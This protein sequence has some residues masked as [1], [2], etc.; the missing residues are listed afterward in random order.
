MQD[1]IALT[2]GDSKKYSVATPGVGTTP[3][4]AAELN[5]Y[6]L[7]IQM[8]RPRREALH[9]LALRSGVPDMNALTALLKG[10]QIRRNDAKKYVA[11]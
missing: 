4:L 6:N 1:I 7:Q 5:L 3:D 9:D 11:A 10:N 8:G 2:K